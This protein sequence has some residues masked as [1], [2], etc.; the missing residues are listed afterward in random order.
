MLFDTDRGTVSPTGTLRI[1]AADDRT[2]HHVVNI[3]GRVRTCSP[4]GLVAGHPAC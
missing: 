3:M 4:N 2:V 1:H